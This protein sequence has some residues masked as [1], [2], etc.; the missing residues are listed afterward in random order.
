VRDR[1]I[2]ARSHLPV[3]HVQAVGVFER[4]R[5]E[6]RRVDDGV[7]RGVDAYAERQRQHGD[8]CIPAFF[9]QESDGEAKILNH[10][11]LQLRRLSF[12][13]VNTVSIQ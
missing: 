12:L 1:R 10:G 3:E 11:V 6:Q 4:K 13:A 9:D 7:D 2:H 5:P 8:G